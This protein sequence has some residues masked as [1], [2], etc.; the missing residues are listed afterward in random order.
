[1]KIILSINNTINLQRI[2][3]LGRD[4]LIYEQLNDMIIK[5]EVLHLN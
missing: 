3:V 5:F 2:F 4:L 1:M